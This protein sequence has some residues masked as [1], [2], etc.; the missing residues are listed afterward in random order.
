MTEHK[1]QLVALALL[2]IVAL[3]LAGCGDFFVDDTPSNTA[4]FA[5]VANNGS[6]N[7]SAYTVG[8]NGPAAATNVL[9]TDTLPTGVNFLSATTSQGSCSGTSTLTCALGSLASGARYTSSV[10]PSAPSR[11]S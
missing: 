4:K 3:V 10:D 7:A 6:G 9:L 8:N 1:N 11:S 5:F 2:V